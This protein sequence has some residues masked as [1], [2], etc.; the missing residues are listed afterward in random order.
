MRDADIDSA[1][2]NLAM[3]YVNAFVNAGFCKD[4]LMIT[5][6]EKESWVYKN[7]EEGMTAAAASMGLLLLWDTDQGLVNMD[8]LLEANNDFI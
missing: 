2:K 1:K 7:K 8:Q 3:T 5:E 6:N 4:L